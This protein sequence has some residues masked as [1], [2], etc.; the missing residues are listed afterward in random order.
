[1]KKEKLIDIDLGANGGRVALYSGEEIDAWITKELD[2]WRWFSD[3]LNQDGNLNNVWNRFWSPIGQVNAIASNLRQTQWLDKG[4]VEQLSNTILQTYSSPDVLHSTSVKG[5]FIEELRQNDALAAAY[6]LAALLKSQIQP[7]SASAFRGIVEAT[8]FEKGIKGNAKPEKK[9]LE[10]ALVVFHSDVAKRSDESDK[11]NNLLDESLTN[12]TELTKLNRE[13][14]EI[15]I[16]ASKESVELMLSNTETK[17]DNVTSTYDEKLALQA[18]VRYWTTK[19]RFHRL[20]REKIGKWLTVGGIISALITCGA[21]WWLLGDSTTLK[22]PEYWRLGLIIIL[23]TVVFWSI[24]LGVKILLSH[25]HLEEDAAQRITMIQTYLSLMRRGQTTS[26][27]DIK[28]ILSALFR[29]T[30]DG[31]VKDE[32]MPTSV[33]DFLTRPTK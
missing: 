24:R 26:A 21:L 15:L 13:Q 12:F 23:L 14:F 2:F 17:L 1:M 32:G 27:E 31:L 22:P 20:A 29:P 3:H 4:M 9:A 33:I 5:H 16:L 8:L 25:L 30:G 19:R 6:A 28:Q 11:L 10:D 18:P 7:A